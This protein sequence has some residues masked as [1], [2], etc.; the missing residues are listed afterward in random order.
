M[1]GSVLLLVLV[2][3][4]EGAGTRRTRQIA[5]GQTAA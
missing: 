2:L 5:V 1:M 3:L 4:V